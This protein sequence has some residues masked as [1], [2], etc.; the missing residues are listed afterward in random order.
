MDGSLMKADAALSS[1]VPK[2]SEKENAPKN[3][4]DPSGNATNIKDSNPSKPSKY[5]KGKKFSNKTHV[6]K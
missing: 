4:D 5:I 3:P 6:S 2:E 1:L